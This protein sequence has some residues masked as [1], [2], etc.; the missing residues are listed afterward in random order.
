M[1]SLDLILVSLVEPTPI[2]QVKPMKNQSSPNRKL[3][4]VSLP[5]KLV[6]KKDLKKLANPPSPSPH[7]P[8]REK[9]IQYILRTRNIVLP[10]L[11]KGP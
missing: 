9:F 8:Q 11:T 4:R 10:K 2:G 6:P 1:F 3:I 7:A 5:P